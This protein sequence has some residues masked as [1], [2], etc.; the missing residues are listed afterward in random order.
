MGSCCA[1]EFGGL[2]WKPRALLFL[3]E[4][5]CCGWLRAI[6]TPDRLRGGFSGWIGEKKRS[7]ANSGERRSLDCGYRAVGGGTEYHPGMFAGFVTEPATS[8]KLVWRHSDCVIETGEHTALFAKHGRQQGALFLPPD[9][10]AGDAGKDKERIE[11]SAISPPR[12]GFPQSVGPRRCAYL[13]T[14]RRAGALIC[15]L[16]S[17]EALKPSKRSRCLPKGSACRRWVLPR[18]PA[19]KMVAKEAGK[20]SSYWPVRLATAPVRGDKTA[21]RGSRYF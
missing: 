3:L 6:L 11:E 17:G 21:L 18:D 4:T 12:T 20:K 2:L 8:L 13:S 1:T 15:Q 14:G 5:C 10:G 16:P 19:L 7:G 9:A